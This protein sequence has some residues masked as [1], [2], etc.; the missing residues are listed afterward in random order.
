MQGEGVAAVRAQSDHGAVENREVV[1]YRSAKQSER[2][3]GRRIL[4]RLAD[5]GHRIFGP[6]AKA[7]IK[8]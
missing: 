3:D 7:T 6:I 2:T 5:T 4:E 8:R 1:R